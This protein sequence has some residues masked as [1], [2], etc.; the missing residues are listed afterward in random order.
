MDESQ[1]KVVWI[2]VAD[3]FDFKADFPESYV[4]DLPTD[5]VPH[6]F[7]SL[8]KICRLSDIMV[9]GENTHHM[10]EACFKVL[11]GDCVEPFAEMVTKF[12]GQGKAYDR[13][14]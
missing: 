7:H 10:V 1:V 5:M 14:Y 12:Q 13:N 3:L 4:G 9:T 2:L 6:V 8:L 11:P